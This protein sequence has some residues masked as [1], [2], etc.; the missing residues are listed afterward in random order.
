MPP[1]LDRAQLLHSAGSLT[2]PRCG[3]PTQFGRPCSASPPATE[4]PTVQPAQIGDTLGAGTYSVPRSE[5]LEL[6]TLLKTTTDSPWPIPC[7]RSYGGYDWE[8]VQ[9]RVGLADGLAHVLSCSPDGPCEISIPEDPGWTYSLGSTVQSPSRHADGAKSAAQLLEQAT[10]GATRE[11]FDSLGAFAS[12]EEW[13][14]DQMFN[15]PPTLHRAYYRQRA[16]PRLSAPSEVAAPRSACEPNSRWSRSAIRGDDQTQNISFSNVVLPGGGNVTAMYIGGVLR[17]E[18]NLAVMRPHGLGDNVRQQPQ[19]GVDNCN[20][21]QRGGLLLDTN[22]VV[23]RIQESDMGLVVIGSACV[24]NAFPG[25]DNPVEIYNTLIHFDQLPYPDTDI[26]GE[27]IEVLELAAGDATLQELEPTTYN[28]GQ[29]LV[30]QLNVDCPFGYWAQFQPAT[31]L[32][33]DGQYYRYDPRAVLLENSLENP[34]EPSSISSGSMRS[35][36]TLEISAPKTFLNEDTCVISHG[37][38]PDQYTGEF[39]LNSTTLRAFFIEGNNLVYAVDDLPVRSDQDPC[40]RTTRWRA[41]GPCAGRATEDL[42]DDA[43]AVLAEYIRSS[44]DTNEII[45]DITLENSDRGQCSNA[46]EAIVDV[47]GEC[48]AH[49]HSDNLNVYNFERMNREWVDNQ[50]QAGYYPVKAAANDR[51]DAIFS[52]PSHQPESYWARIGKPYAAAGPTLG[53]LGDTVSFDDLP[54][55][56]RSKGIAEAV[57][58]AVSPAEGVAGVE[59]CGSPGEVANDPTLGQRFYFGKERYNSDGARTQQYQLNNYRGNPPTQK[60]AIHTSIALY[61]PDQLRQRVAWALSQT[62][63]IAEFGSAIL[64]GHAEVWT[65]YYDIFVRNAFGNYRDI[66]REV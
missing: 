25:A 4:L 34:A 36:P 42:S 28:T 29:M 8:V 50:E 43:K 61:S 55:G 57:G 39:Q 48:W 10:F 1:Q 15:Q 65:L 16:N 22:Y 7:A 44:P 45:K 17:S 54:H 66:L 19:P 5:A 13:V 58:V 3:R 47:D 35:C 53:R 51:D 2:H 41:L 46:L 59:M 37:C 27:P 12:E 49:T 23:C 14:L 63:V 11:A 33:I 64:P 24:D 62:L 18:V 20:W 31:T 21:C 6:L 32:K 9:P 52:W 30:S 60:Q 26:L 38:G 56:V 40:R